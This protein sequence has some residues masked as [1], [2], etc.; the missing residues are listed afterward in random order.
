MKELKG[1]VTCDTLINNE[2]G[3]ISPVMEI[4]DLG[5][6]YSKNRKQYYSDVDPIYSL[7]AFW[8][9]EERK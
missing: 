7:H 2:K 8:G 9:D 6:T 5:L 1:F 3:V 4:S